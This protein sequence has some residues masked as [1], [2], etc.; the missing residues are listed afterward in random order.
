MRESIDP[1]IGSSFAFGYAFF[2]YA[3]L[4]SLDTPITGTTGILPVIG[5]AGVSPIIGV[6]GV[7]PATGTTG[8][9]PV[10]GGRAL[11][12]SRPYSTLTSN[13][14]PFGPVALPVP[15]PSTTTPITLTV[16]FFNFPP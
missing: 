2:A 1:R 14:I 9:P 12:A 5:V 8:V 15:F 3:A 4:L 6:A 10:A 13:L 7:S 11:R 16:N